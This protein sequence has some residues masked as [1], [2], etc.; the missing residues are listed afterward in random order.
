MK[1]YYF[2]LGFVFL[3]ILSN[4]Q[5]CY[6]QQKVDY[7]IKV[8]LNAENHT[9]EGV[10]NIKYSN[11][12]PEALN[13]IYFHLFWNAF[14][15]NSSMDNKSRLLEKVLIPRR[16]SATPDWDS[17]VKDRILQL[18]DSEIGK[19]DILKIMIDGKPVKFKIVETIL[20]IDL[21]QN[22]L[23]N[24]C[25]NIE[26]TFTSQVPN[27]VRRSGRNN[28]ENIM[29]SMAQWYPK[30]AEY[31]HLGW[32]TNQYIARE[33]YGVWGNF[34]V[35]ILIDKKFTVAASGNL[36]NLAIPIS[37]LKAG[38]TVLNYE[39]DKTKAIDNKVHWIFEAQNVHDFVWAADTAYKHIGL[40]VK[41]NLVFQA[42]FK[43]NGQELEANW[44][45]ILWS[46]AKLLPHIEKKFGAYPYNRYSFIQGGDGGMEYPMAT[47][48]KS[49]DLSTAIHEFMHSWYQGIL[50]TNEY[51]YPWMDEGFTEY[52]Q[53]YL[54]N[55]YLDSLIQQDNYIDYKLKQKLIER[56][57]KNKQDN[58]NIYFQ[59]YKD[60]L[61]YI[62]SPFFEPLS[63]P[64]DYFATNYAYSQ[65][66]YNRGAMFLVILGYIIGQD[67]LDKV[68]LNYYNQWKFKHPT[69]D[70]FMNIAEQT[71][72]IKLH[73]FKEF[74]V[75]TTKKIEISIVKISNNHNMPTVRITR[76]EPFPMPLD[77]LVTYRDS[78]QEWF[79]IPIDLML[80]SKKPETSLPTTILPFWQSTNPHYAFELKRKVSEIK[81]IELD[82]YFHL[83]ETHKVDNKLVL[84]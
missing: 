13:K 71:S 39:V 73:W 28:A 21:N 46:M 80:H 35:D 70:D 4:A 72:G 78:S 67:N 84:P 9:L 30:L 69:P 33:F 17:R 22:V 31:D 48:L 8:S 68:L 66:S 1:K 43:N 12:A 26:L 23:P 36:T 24:S 47:L 61:R 25:I 20:E 50:A 45:R 54:Y 27:Q 37:N 6:W 34:K 77:V 57:V 19:V 49:S 5:N 63:T 41:P 55:F 15:P 64:A 62:N 75:N 53:E 81:S 79:Y 10:E 11:N 3:T 7:D 44:Q 82:P 52:A 40:V 60:A 58:P 59:I 32:H 76:K 42:Y 38:E 29:Y 83:P 65:S 2:I 74:Y 14:Q 51:L 56:H 16:D 18:K